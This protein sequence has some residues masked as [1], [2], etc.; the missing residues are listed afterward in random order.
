MHGL[1]RCRRY[2]SKEMETTRR[3]C[4]LAGPWP[5]AGLAAQQ[6]T[7]GTS[8]QYG[9]R[10]SRYG[11]PET[12]HAIGLA[13]HRGN[14]PVCSRQLR[15]G[16]GRWT[17]RQCC[18]LH[19][20]SRACTQTRGKRRTRLCMA[21][22][23]HLDVAY[24]RDGEWAGKP[25]VGPGKQHGRVLALGVVLLPEFPDLVHAV[26]LREHVADIRFL[27]SV[28]VAPPARA[29]VDAAVDFAPAAVS[30]A[31][32]AR[33]VRGHNPPPGAQHTA[34][35]AQHGRKTEGSSSCSTEM[36]SWWMA[37]AATARMLRAAAKSAAKS[38]A[39]NRAGG[40]TGQVQRCQACRLASDASSRSKQGRRTV[41]PP[42]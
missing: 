42:H 21:G 12:M 9:G 10:H 4:T 11:Q 3:A 33:R 24:D 17:A 6:D 38:A 31:E 15:S 41:L 2:G 28:R 26:Q 39:K 8:P 1:L 18:P 37:C 34:C 7:A 5:S 35:G 25:D 22:A 30:G 36:W 40:L 16:A 23:A 19:R 29:V 14:Q 27:D 13:R 20:Q 32:R